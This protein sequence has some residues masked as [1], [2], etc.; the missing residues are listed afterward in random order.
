V[1]Y[2]NKIQLAVTKNSYRYVLLSI[3]KPGV[4]IS[5]HVP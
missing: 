3:F 2:A 1:R 5:G 4:F